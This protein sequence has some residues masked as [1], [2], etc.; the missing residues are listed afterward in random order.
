MVLR[1]QKTRRSVQIQINHKCCETLSR[2]R[3]RKDNLERRK[4]RKSI[5]NLELVKAESLGLTVSANFEDA[6]NTIWTSESSIRSTSKQGWEKCVKSDGNLYTY[7]YIAMVKVK[8]KV[9]RTRLES[10][11]GVRGIAL[12]SL[13]LG[14]RRGWV[15]STTPRPLYPRERPGTHCTGGWVYIDMAFIS[16]PCKSPTQRMIL[17]AKWLLDVPP[18]LKMKTFYGLPTGCL[19]VRLLRF[20]FIKEAEL[21]YC[22][23][24]TWFYIQFR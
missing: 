14:A 15:V 11:E 17:K 8:V 18:G 3:T 5:W 6:E 4:L 13:D 20:G 16:L 21:V 2:P 7:L 10:P 9:P 22:A 24:Q 23:G 19:S 12:H 1:F